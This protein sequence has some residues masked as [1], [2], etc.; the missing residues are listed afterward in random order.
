MIS[1]T[2]QSSTIAP[3][4][5]SKSTEFVKHCFSETQNVFDKSSETVLQNLKNYCFIYSHVVNT[6]T[7]IYNHNNK[8]LIKHP[9]QN[10]YNSIY[11]NKKPSNI[12]DCNSNNLYYDNYENK[13][14]YVHRTMYTY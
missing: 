7:C 12:L 14:I 10:N 5:K 4:Q 6:Y 2:V 8:T 1:L 9:I 3:D 11:F 13:F